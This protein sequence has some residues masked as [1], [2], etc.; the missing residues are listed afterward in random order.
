MNNLI[1][2][3]QNL[4][5][6]SLL[7][8]LHA[9]Y[10]VP[11]ESSDYYA[12]HLQSEKLFKDLSYRLNGLAFK[13]VYELFEL[14]FEYALF[15][16]YKLQNREQAIKHLAL[17]NTYGAFAVSYGNDYAS[18]VDN[19]QPFIPMNKGT[20]ILASLILG[21][22]PEKAKLVGHNFLSSLNKESV[23]IKRG[24]A[25][26]HIGWF[27]MALFIKKYD[28]E[29]NLHKAFFPKEFEL[30][31]EVLEH[32]DTEDP[33]LL[34]KMVIILADNHLA[35]AKIS[36]AVNLDN[37]ENHTANFS[38]LFLPGLY[39]LPY[40]LLV[41]FKLREWQGLKTYRLFNPYWQG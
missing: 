17:A 9:K 13:S 7:N 23:I 2:E 30:F 5:E 38:E 39:L 25:S 4:Y 26:A 19:P 31:E 29:L 18:K 24:Q 35:E 15:C 6:D 40:E 11:I 16:H 10:Q 3:L 8:D 28:L 32:W 36:S 14:H 34:E 22:Q 21:N 33:V 41:W 1:L 37:I 27:I 12:I 20:L